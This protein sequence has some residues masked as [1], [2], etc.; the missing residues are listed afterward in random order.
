MSVG[1]QAE[2]N[3][4]KKD[5]L[6]LIK[7][8][9]KESCKVEAVWDVKTVGSLCDSEEKSQKSRRLLALKAAVCP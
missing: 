8:K 6:D 1:L 3:Y 5:V 7:K 9:K 4:C 2:N